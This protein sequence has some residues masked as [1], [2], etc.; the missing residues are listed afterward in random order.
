MTRVFV[1]GT[2]LILATLLT[3]QVFAQA[4]YRVSGQLELASDN[5][6]DDGFD[7]VAQYSSGF[8][9]KFAVPGGQT[10]IDNVQVDGGSQT[11]YSGINLTD[12]SFDNGNLDI[13]DSVVPGEFVYWDRADFSQHVLQLSFDLG[14]SV[15]RIVF[16]AD[17]NNSDMAF[18]QLFVP[19]TPEPNIGDFD[20]IQF[21]TAV[22]ASNLFTE[23]QITIEAGTNP[24]GGS[25]LYVGD[26]DFQ[27]REIL[28][29]DVNLDDQISLLDVA[30]FIALITSGQFQAEADV[31]L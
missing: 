1:S 4:A 20:P 15:I 29:G 14:E 22:E 2:A 3:Q 6:P 13:V 30:P 7:F 25:G 11:T 28:V 16:T 12:L 18:G 10:L 19:A 8:S 27:S 26:L 23:P 24:F 9:M 17:E 31:N 21:F 5:N